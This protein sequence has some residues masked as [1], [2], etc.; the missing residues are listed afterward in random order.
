[1]EYHEYKYV[2]TYVIIEILQRKWASGTEAC[3]NLC[4]YE[5]SHTNI[6]TEKILF[7]VEILFCFARKQ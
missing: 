2:N 1:M 6:I 7:N 4:F 3:Q 5:R